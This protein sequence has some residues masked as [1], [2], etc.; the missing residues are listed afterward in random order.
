MKVTSLNADKIILLRKKRKYLLSVM[1]KRYFSF[2]H[3]KRAALRNLVCIRET[4]ISTGFTAFGGS[5]SAPAGEVPIVPGVPSP[6]AGGPRQGAELQGCT[7]KATASTKRMK[8]S[9]TSQHLWVPR[10]IENTKT[11]SFT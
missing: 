5:H 2:H 10:G 4:L 1:Q 9:N 11:T 6:E 8:L 7:A 3:L